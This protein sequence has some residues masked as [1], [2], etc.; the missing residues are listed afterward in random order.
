[1]SRTKKRSGIEIFREAEEISKKQQKSN[2]GGCYIATM[3][4]GDYEHPQVMVLREFRD[5]FLSK[6]LIGRSFIKFYYRYS[7]NW[8]ETMKNM[9]PVNLF[10]RFVLN[11]IILIIK[12]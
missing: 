1:M 3:V 10:I 5:N 4:Y 7:P 6:H 8:V 12:K 9:K 11:K 2:S